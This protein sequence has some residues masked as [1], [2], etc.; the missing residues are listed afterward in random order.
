MAT[1]RKSTAE[2]KASAAPKATRSNPAQDL[3]DAMTKPFKGMTERLQ[4]LNVSGAAGA[5]LD[6]GRKDLQALVQANEKSY[7]GLQAVVQ[8]QTELL[9]SSIG[10]WQGVVKSLPGKDPKEGFAQLDEMGKTAFK[11]ALDDMKELADLAAKS[12]ADAFNL[13]RDR[14]NDNVEQARKMLQQPGK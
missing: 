5:L 9:K 13:V 12:Q 3:Q 2:K 11:R 14:I 8:R 10:E 6:S 4:N 7:K 1:S